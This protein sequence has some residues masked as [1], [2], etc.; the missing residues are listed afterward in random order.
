MFNLARVIVFVSGATVSASIPEISLQ[1][2]K[3]VDGVGDVYYLANIPAS[4]QSE[5]MIRYTQRK[6]LEKIKEIGNPFSVL[7]IY[8]EVKDLTSIRSILEDKEANKLCTSVKLVFGDRIWN[9]QMRDELT[10]LLK[11]YEGK[12]SAFR[13]FTRPE[14]HGIMI[15]NKIMLEERH[16]ISDMYKKVEVIENA[17]EQ[18]KNVFENEFYNLQLDSIQM[19]PSTCKDLVLYNINT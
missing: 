17:T 13:H 1:K 11:M 5:S 3:H 7:C 12:F 8:G 2:P 6:W 19:T 4:N 14:D 10:E 15:S 16:A 18:A 9:S